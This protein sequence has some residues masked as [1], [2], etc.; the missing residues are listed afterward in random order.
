MTNIYALFIEA[1]WL[2]DMAKAE[3]FLPHGGGKALTSMSELS[4]VSDLQTVSDV[5]YCDIDYLF[6]YGSFVFG[7][8]SWTYNAV[9]STGST[10]I[11]AV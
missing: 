5:S 11:I 2:V 1:D 4:F 10:S 6:N 9:I 3:A 7:A 8:L